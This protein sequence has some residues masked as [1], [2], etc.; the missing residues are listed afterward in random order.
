MK[1][2]DFGGCFCCFALLCFVLLCFALFCFVLFFFGGGAAS[3]LRVPIHSGDAHRHP[4]ILLRE[5][6]ACPLAPQPFDA[7]RSTALQKESNEFK[8]NGCILA[9]LSILQE[10]KPSFH[11]LR[12]PLPLL[13]H[14]F[15]SS[16]PI[17]LSS[18]LPF[19]YPFSFSPVHSFYS[20]FKE[21]LG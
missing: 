21:V 9:E 7:D 10:L 14:P 20:S 17:S 6:K 8:G 4:S 15:P 18:P 11:I 16:L 2:R 3:H 19:P 5:R 1:G 12:I 13:S